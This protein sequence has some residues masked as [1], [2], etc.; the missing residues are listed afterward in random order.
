MKPDKVIDEV[1]MPSY[2][3][4]YKPQE[5]ISKVSF[6]VREL[7]HKKISGSCSD[8]QFRSDVM[9]PLKFEELMDRQ[10]A[11]LSDGELQRVALC[12]CL[13]KVI[14]LPTV[15]PPPPLLGQYSIRV[16]SSL[17]EALDLLINQIFSPFTREAS[18][19]IY[20]SEA[21]KLSISLTT[22]NRLGL[23]IYNRNRQGL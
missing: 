15:P 5:L 9:K 19:S 21:Y 20:M 7:V 11:N 18:V 14:I 23:L 4:S 13:G 12:L 3:V 8:A 10:D 6:T 16:E 22:L 17:L 1:D 2:T